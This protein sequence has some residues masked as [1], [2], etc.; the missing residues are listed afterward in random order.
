MKRY[1]GVIL[2]IISLISFMS[3][4]REF[5]YRGGEEGLY[6]SNDTVTFDTIFTTIGSTTQNFK[7]YNPYIEDMTITNISLAGGENSN[8]RI[9][10]NGYSDT[11]IAEIPIRAKD[12]LFVFVEVTVDPSGGDEP[13]VVTDSI[14]FETSERLQSVKLIAYGQDIVLMKQE[15]LKTSHLT[16]DKPY[17]IYDYL[18]VDST[19]TVTIDPGARLYFYKDASLLVLGTLNVEGSIEEPVLFA[20]HRLENWYSDKPGQWGYIHLLPGSGKSTFNN[21]IIRNGMIG[22]LADSVGMN[23]EPIE[24]HNTKIE[25]ISSF[26][27][28]AQTSGITAS[29]TVIGNCGNNAVAL[30]V[31]GE[32]DFS[33]CTMV[34]TDY[35]F[36]R[37]GAMV[38]LN[39]YYYDNDENIHITPLIKADFNN[40]IIYGSYADELSTDFQFTD[41]SI[42]E[43]EADYLFNHCLLRLSSSFDTSNT[44]NF[45]SII[46]D[47]VPGFINS[48]EY[49]YQL[50]TLS[51]A[52]DIGDISVAEKYPTDILNVNRLDDD[53]PD[54]GAYERH[55][56][57]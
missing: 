9:N 8:F 23:D 10:V 13:F 12:S 5:I 33:H 30:T 21:A 36:G 3:C 27:I 29:N 16:K 38:F 7:V 35:D 18:V 4:E 15:W 20:S 17:L 22:I 53:G 45:K 28:L 39:N 56:K 11:E 1:L 51:I 37:S 57:K 50:D 40:C 42:P 48:D 2:V 47:Q 31:G 54:L 46:T 52:K 55:E 6:F 24:I 44:N 43:S 19:E 14:V 32:Y 26:G 25:H 41:E 34:T 49:N